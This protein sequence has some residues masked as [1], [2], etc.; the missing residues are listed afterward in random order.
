MLTF[1]SSIVLLVLAYFTYGKYVEKVFGADENRE[2]PAIK[3]PDGVDFVPMSTTKNFLIQF[4]NIAGLG[5]IFGPILGALYGPI[6]FL[7][8]I[9]GSI[10]AGGVHDYMSGM[11]SVRSN[12]KTMAEITGDYLGEFSRYAM[13]FISVML[14]L[15]VGIVFIVGPAALLANLTFQPM[16]DGVFKG[17]MFAN[18]E[19]W[20]AIIFVYYFL[21]TI[22]PIDKIIG[23][24]Y[25]FFGAILMFMAF[26]VGGAMVYHGLA[27]PELTDWANYTHPGGVPIWPG[28]I[29][30]ISCGAISGF[31]A[32]QSP[33][34]ARTLKNEK[35]GRIVF[36]GAMLTESFIAMIWASVGMAFFP[37]GISGLN[38]V[39]TKGG[40]GLV[41][42][43]VTVGYLGAAGGL[44]AIL[45]VII[46]PITSGDTAFRS[47]RLSVSDRFKLSQGKII[48]RLLIAIPIFIIAYFITKIGFKSIWIY[49]SFS[50]QLLST[51]VLWTAVAYLYAHGKNFWIA[52]VPVI[53]MS[54]SIVGY[55]LTA[56]VF[57]FGLSHTVALNSGYATGLAVFAV[58]I[59]LSFSSKKRKLKPEFITTDNKIK[60]AD[61]ENIIL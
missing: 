40:P 58:L 47:I 20:I 56:K 14:L 12:G 31:H 7:W 57:P 55:V 38:E 32:T 19:I 17:T 6:A 26:G 36:Y 25:P 22:I 27:I 43:E 28:L 49:F 60:E 33:M 21:S 4:L 24:I 39:L 29:F 35:K 18:K 61:T 34:V 41:V 30:T 9:A 46:A 51:F 15:F 23:R 3:E 50:N 44:L 11:M 8:I 45:G 52:G 10:F 42:N 59:M 16:G 54:A 48:N 1:F 53:F 5:P 2:T 13:L 37:H